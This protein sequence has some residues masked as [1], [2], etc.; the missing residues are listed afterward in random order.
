[1]GIR[2]G[3]ETFGI[4]FDIAARFF[5]PLPLRAVFQIQNLH[6]TANLLSVHWEVFNPLIPLINTLVC[7]MLGGPREIS[8][9]GL[10]NS[11]ASKMGGGGPSHEDFPV[12]AKIGH[13]NFFF[14]DAS[15]AW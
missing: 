5:E 11:G 8:S 10:H 13:G 9:D 12:A 6:P 14:T 1:M 3:F 15:N 7:P 4:L 2:R